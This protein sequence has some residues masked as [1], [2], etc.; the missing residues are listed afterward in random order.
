[1]DQIKKD[2][3]YKK[4]SQNMVMDQDAVLMKDCSR[5]GDKRHT[6]QKAEFSCKPVQSINPKFHYTVTIL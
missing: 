6:V 4:K 3:F 1:M 5:A 2:F